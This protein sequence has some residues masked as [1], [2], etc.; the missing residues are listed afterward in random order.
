[1]NQ[2]RSVLLLAGQAALALLGCG[3]L[4]LGG[5]ALL[6][7]LGLTFPPLR[8]FLQSAGFHIRGVAAGLVLFV[9]GTVQLTIAIAGLRGMG[10]RRRRGDVDLE[11][12]AEKADIQADREARS[13]RRD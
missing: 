2:S 12:P 8:E 6:R 4:I 11:F 5:E 3:L 13:V 7:P 1:M 10:E 9:A